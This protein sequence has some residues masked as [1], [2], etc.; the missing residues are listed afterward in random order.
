M[1]H[2][3]KHLLLNRNGGTSES[4]LLFIGI[5]PYAD[6]LCRL[7]GRERPTKNAQTI[8]AEKNYINFLKDKWLM[9]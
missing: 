5:G 2:L 8:S 3:K 9:L 6:T 7:D 4:D 1:T